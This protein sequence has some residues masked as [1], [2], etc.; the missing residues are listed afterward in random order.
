MFCYS[1]IHS[2]TR[3]QALSEP[4][5]ANVQCPL[6][7]SPACYPF[8]WCYP[9]GCC[10]ITHQFH[11]EV[12]LAGSF[13]PALEVSRKL[14]QLLQWTEILACLLSRSLN[15]LHG[16]EYEKLPFPLW[17][18][19]SQARILAY[20]FTPV[21]M[22]DQLQKLGLGAVTPWKYQLRSVSWPSITP[23]HFSVSRCGSPVFWLAD[24]E[25]SVLEWRLGAPS[26]LF[27]EVGFLFSAVNT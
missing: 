3:R 8:A 26:W 23:P 15:T 24:T 4:Q 5:L 19:L 14:R 13:L 10:R 16:G 21:L 11:T 27:H 25:K 1:C 18:S 20:V 12:Q 17:G 2:K 6:A 9:A 7:L 22:L